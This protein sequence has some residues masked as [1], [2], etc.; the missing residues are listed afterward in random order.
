[1]SEKCQKVMAD[2]QEKKGKDFDKA[3]EPDG[4]GS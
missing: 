3:Y 1:M 2:L 4:F